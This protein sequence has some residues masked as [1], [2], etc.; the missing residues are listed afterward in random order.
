MHKVK[1]EHSFPLLKTMFITGLC[2]LLLII[3][4]SVVDYY[5]SR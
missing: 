5:M 4:I 3:G 1:V 2:I